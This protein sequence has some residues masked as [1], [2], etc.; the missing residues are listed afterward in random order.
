MTQTRVL[1]EGQMTV[2]EAMG[3]A[4]AAWVG[5]EAGWVGWEVAGWAAGLEAGGLE[6]WEEAMAAAEARGSCLQSSTKR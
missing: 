5:P 1:P 6:D 2:W 4:A 3:S